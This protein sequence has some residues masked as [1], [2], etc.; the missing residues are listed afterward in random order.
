MENEEII[1]YWATDTDL[2]INVDG[3]EETINVDEALIKYFDNEKVLNK[4]DE[5]FKK[6]ENFS[7]RDFEE[8]YGENAKDSLFDGLISDLYTGDAENTNAVD[9]KV[10][11]FVTIYEE[12]ANTL[13]Y[14]EEY[15]RRSKDE[16]RAEGLSAYQTRK[17]DI[18]RTKIDKRGVCTTFSMRLSEELTSLGIENYF[19]VVQKPEL[20]H[21]VNLYKKGE[22]FVVAD[23]TEDIV[24]GNYA[25]QLGLPIDRIPALSAQ[26]PVSE[27]L[28][29]NPECFV[30]EEIKND[31]RKFEQM[32]MTK[33]GDFLRDKSAEKE[34]ESEII[35]HDLG[36]IEPD[37]E[38]SDLEEAQT[39]S[40]TSE[41]FLEREEFY[42][43]T[44]YDIGRKMI[45]GQSDYTLK[46]EEFG[47]KLGIDTE[48]PNIGMTYNNKLNE[49]S[50][51][52]KNAGISMFAEIDEKYDYVRSSFVGDAI[53]DD[54]A[55]KLSSSLD[56]LREYN[57]SIE[58]VITEK[59]NQINEQKN[60]GVMQKLFSKIKVFFG[61]K[62]ALP[63]QTSHLKEAIEE[64][65]GNLLKYRQIDNSIYEYNLNDDVTQSIVSFIDKNDFSKDFIPEIVDEGVI[66][67]LQKLGL[68][69]LIPGLQEQ[70]SQAKEQEDL[71][72]LKSWEL[73]KSQ[74]NEI[75]QA[76]KRIS[77]EHGEK[78][79]NETE[80]DIEENEI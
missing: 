70:L 71:T 8:I 30:V 36:T 10:Q 11:K 28:K 26:I 31:G 33:I 42:K 54:L 52:F 51:L 5:I 2:Y 17:N 56:I 39:S 38:V 67:I 48:M 24:Q 40:I 60:V 32:S 49:L 25:R 45:A 34:E 7:D 55:C 9:E 73:S 80:I 68:E 63:S 69:N 72:E 3:K 74:K 6:K 47:E 66:P 27:F 46:L 19:L 18:E 59:E 79:D 16:D 62:P 35:V 13:T 12:L 15:A 43:K 20:I 22:N 4:I 53:L 76:Q 23:I 1:V 65:N 29:E 50:Q 77:E 75:L 78:S 57:K 14:D 44:A 64:V 61:G 41:T 37:F 21:W 58:K